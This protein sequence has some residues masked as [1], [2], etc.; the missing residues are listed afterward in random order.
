MRT[1][2]PK[3]KGK[4]IYVSPGSGKTTLASQNNCFIDTDELM[5]GEIQILHPD[6]PKLKTESIQNYIRRFTD[7]FKYKTKINNRVIKRCQEFLD[8]NLTVLTGTIKIAEKADFV[9]L[10]PPT[11]LRVQSRFGGFENANIWHQ[12]EINFL[13]SKNI[14]F[15]I[16]NT[17]IEDH[18]FK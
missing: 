1:L 13:N 4:L 8:R 2:N 5:V 18:I 12:E 6:F 10:I 7:T 15:E 16:L 3:Y 17:Q 14:H 11:N 9:F